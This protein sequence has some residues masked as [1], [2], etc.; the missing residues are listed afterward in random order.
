[1]EMISSGI[2]SSTNKEK[3]PSGKSR[4]SKHKGF[5]YS[6]K[7]SI[8][9]AKATKVLMKARYSAVEGETD[10]QHY[11]L[12]RKAKLSPQQFEIGM[13]L[14][15]I[16]LMQDKSFKS[17]LIYTK[18]ATLS[19]KFARYSNYLSKKEL[20]HDHVPED[21]VMKKALVKL[22]EVGVIDF[23]RSPDKAKDRQGNLVTYITFRKL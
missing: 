18:M 12:K 15:N 6:R 5:R 13:Y 9:V 20:N 23:E 19:F 22:K 1:M 8:Y 21:K 4:S 11:T 17:P 2:P 10:K 3:T 16:F 7:K 14:L